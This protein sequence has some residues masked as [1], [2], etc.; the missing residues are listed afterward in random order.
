MPGL[1]NRSFQFSYCTA[2]T[3]IPI[4]YCFLQH[5]Q[6]RLGCSQCEWGITEIYNAICLKVGAK[7][8][9][10]TN[11]L[12]VASS[13]TWVISG[14]NG[15]ATFNNTVEHHSLADWAK[16][17]VKHMDVRYMPLPPNTGWERTEMKYPRKIIK[18]LWH[19]SNWSATQKEQE[20][21]KNQALAT[22]PTVTESVLCVESKWQ[23]CSL[24]WKGGNKK[25]ER[26]GKK[27]EDG[28]QR[29]GETKSQG[30]WKDVEGQCG[31]RYRQ[32]TT[33]TNM[34]PCQILEVFVMFSFFSV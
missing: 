34:T 12:M 18:G 2:S 29:T 24:W 19:W 23:C 1:V 6:A 21:R 15:Y 4:Y 25:K 9:D 10:V 7:T 14:V 11:N 8:R 16:Y 31:Q 13:E 28:V 33:K 20:E 30:W 32:E 22:Y 27:N 26:I 17:W 5:E 3:C